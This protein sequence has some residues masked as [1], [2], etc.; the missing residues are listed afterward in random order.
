MVLK[1]SLLLLERLFGFVVP[2][3]VYME[4][5]KRRHIYPFTFRTLSGLLLHITIRLLSLPF[6][7]QSVSCRNRLMA[8]LIVCFFKF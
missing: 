4:M 5:N 3:R 7:P 2:M 1:A 8:R 6:L